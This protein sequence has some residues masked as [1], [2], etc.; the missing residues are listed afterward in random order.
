MLANF[1]ESDF[2]EGEGGLLNRKIKEVPFI[3]YSQGHGHLDSFSFWLRDT[4]LE[5]KFWV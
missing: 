5:T 3:W 4:G 2:R 1:G